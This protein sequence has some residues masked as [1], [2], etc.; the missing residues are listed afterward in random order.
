MA[1]KFRCYLGLHR[2]RPRYVWHEQAFPVAFL[3]VQGVSHYRYK[4][5]DCQDCH[6]RLDSPRHDWREI[7]GHGCWAL[8]T[9][10]AVV[11]GLWFAP[12]VTAAI[13]AF[14]AAMFVFLFGVL[15]SAS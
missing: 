8:P 5:D 7:A 12:L 13:L 15:W 1:K 6:A 14:V 11:A 9:A 3:G 10:A 2:W 4:H